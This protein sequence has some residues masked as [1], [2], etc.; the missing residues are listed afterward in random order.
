MP[1]PELLNPPA[2]PVAWNPARLLLMSWH[3]PPGQG[4]GALRWQKLAALAAERGWALDVVT[5]H[6][7]T[8]PSAD[9][10]RLRELP[11]GTRVFGVRAP[12]RPLRDA[13]GR[14]RR[15]LTV[16]RRSAAN[17]SA[18]PV[19]PSPFHPFTPSPPHPFPPDAGLAWRADLRWSAS[20]RALAR[21]LRA[22]RAFADEDGWARA[23]QRAAGE[24]VDPALHRAVV[25]CGPPHMVHGAGAR[26]ARSIGVPLVM[27]MRDPW[28][29]APATLRATGSPLWYALAER[30]ERAAVRAAALVVANTA[31]AAEAL[32]A[33]HPRAAERIVAVMNGCDDEPLPARREEG[34]F[35]VAYAGSIYIDRDPR[36]LFRAAAAVVRETGIGPERFGMEF[37]GHAEAFG[38]TPLRALAEAEGI[39]GYVSVHPRRPRA[40]ALRMLA[41]ASVLLSL[42]QGVDLAI[43]SKLFEY[44]QFPAWVLAMA[45][46]GSATERL[47]RGT[48]ADVVAPG[49]E[50]A[51]A[52]ALRARLAQWTAG[53]RPRPL[54]ADG[55]FSRRRQADAL[56]RE[57][58][59]R[60]GAPGAPRQGRAA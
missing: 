26:V 30:Y 14:I 44:M 40:E 51:L 41:G 39:G 57:I 21:A 46:P 54:N 49:D 50:A 17:A 43:P 9:A 55:R 60:T 45:A 59:A 8:L 22:W 20:P 34:R 35:V 52:R 7:D 13:A 10:D 48:D 29:L 19:T 38:G 15:A 33:A 37:V 31:A 4:A 42:P 47:L 27:D 18:S 5:A 3:F 53:E 16:L 2:Q 58:E 25:T 23:A 36:A 6:P 24:V 32:R 12:A 56:F 1:P 28:S 11:P